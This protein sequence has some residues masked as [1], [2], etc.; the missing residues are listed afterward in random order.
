MEEIEK[1]DSAA[2]EKSPE[3]HPV[4][5]AGRISALAM[6]TVCVSSGLYMA[7]QGT[8]PAILHTVFIAGISLFALAI[9]G[10]IPKEQ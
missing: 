10:K 4:G 1:Q 2:V 6:G 5:K 7:F 8:D 9:T 3:S